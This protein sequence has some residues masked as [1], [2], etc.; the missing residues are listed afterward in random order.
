MSFLLLLCK[1]MSFSPV[2][3]YIRVMLCFHSFFFSNAPPTV[4]ANL[5]FLLTLCPCKS[6]VPRPRS[7]A[8]LVPAYHVAVRVWDYRGMLPSLLYSDPPLVSLVLTH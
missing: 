2:F 1:V 5:M 8:V 7:G 6:R 3:S 4:P